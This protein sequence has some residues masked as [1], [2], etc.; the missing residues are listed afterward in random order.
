MCKGCT[1]LRA[2]YTTTMS[3]AVLLLSYN[4]PDLVELQLSTLLRKKRCPTVYISVDGPKADATDQQAVSEVLSVI[5]RFQKKYP[6]A[7]HLQALPKNVGCQKGVEQGIDWFFSQVDEGIILEDDCQ[8]HPDFFRYC[9]DLLE[10][11]RTDDR[12]GMIAGSNPLEQVKLDSDYFFSHQSII[13]GWATW[14]RSWKSYHHFKKTAAKVLTQPDMRQRLTRF[15]TSKHLKT[16]TAVIKGKIDTWDYIWYFT[17]LAESRFSIIPR[18]NL[19]SNVGFANRATHTK[20]KTTQ[21]RLPV[22]AQHFPLVAP[23][24]MLSFDTFEKE[25]LAQVKPWN[26]ARSI[27]RA[28]LG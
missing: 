8:P 2:L 5:T 27:I 16:L 26:V 23:D 13:W 12:I 14:K 28:Y 6:Q 9:D 25:Y 20:I 17:N 3:S 4:R 7:I 21:S 15:T 24:W 11:Y 18:R 22:Y 1:P 10:R 19:I